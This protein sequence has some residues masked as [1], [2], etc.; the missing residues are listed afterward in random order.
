MTH[1]R[2]H[3]VYPRDERGLIVALLVGS[4]GLGGAERSTLELAAADR[5]RGGDFVVIA[6]D[7]GHGAVSQL[8]DRLDV[9]LI[10]VQGLAGALRTLRSLRPTVVWPFGL[11]W[12]LLIRVAVRKASVQDRQGRRPLVLSA[13]RGLDTWR[14]PWHNLVDRVTSPRVDRYVANSHAARR[15]LVDAVGI[16][17]SR[18]ITIWS[19]VDEAWLSPLPPRGA[20]DT[21]RIIIVG[22]DRS[23]KGHPDA[24]QVL[25]SLATRDDWVATIYTSRSVALTRHVSALDLHGRVTVVS[26]HSLTPEDYDG[27]D[28]LLH[29]SHAESLPRAVLEA[30]ARGLGVVATD[31]GDVAELVGDE[32][33]VVPA[34]DQSAIA[35][36]LTAALDDARDGVDPARGAARQARCP[37]QEAVIHELRALVGSLG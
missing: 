9:P 37:S 3:P 6:R 18:S 34:G 28:V 15:M 1:A 21:V 16:E 7:H 4:G 8:A 30:L 12:S 5:A 22:T 19:G 27:S 13:Q 31:V 33:R 10:R 25:A 2:P 20:R 32:G 35:A 17:P 23:E 36:A 29:T 11:R 26:G 24:L 14:R